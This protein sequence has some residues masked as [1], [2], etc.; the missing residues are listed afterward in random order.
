MKKAKKKTRK[1]RSSLRDLLHESRNYI[2]DLLNV[3]Q[4][5]ENERDEAVKA[6]KTWTL[7]ED[8]RAKRRTAVYEAMNTVADAGR[9]LPGLYVLDA[10]GRPAFTSQ[11]AANFVNALNAYEA[12]KGGAVPAVNAE[13]ESA[14]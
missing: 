4:R 8:S 3:Q 9:N 6:I 1:R 2:N 7:D 12:S 11:A 5:I 13:M 10:D 14:T